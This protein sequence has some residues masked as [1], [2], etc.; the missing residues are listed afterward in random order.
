MPIDPESLEWR[1][2][3]GRKRDRGRAGVYV[4]T[5]ERGVV[6]A[7]KSRDVWSRVKAHMDNP[8]FVMLCR[9]I[10]KIE[11][12]WAPLPENAIS[13][14]ESNILLTLSPPGNSSNRA[15]RKGPRQNGSMVVSLNRPHS[16]REEHGLSE[17][18]W[19]RLLDC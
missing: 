14:V 15:S 10:G 9:A 2:F 4:A 16:P 6:Y 18:E 11:F 1:C 17:E 13:E 19:V 8:W 5:H 7:G 12:M 3:T